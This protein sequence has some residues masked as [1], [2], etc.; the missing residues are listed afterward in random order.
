M[1]GA[2]KHATTFPGVPK[3]PRPGDAVW[4]A[5]RPL[6]PVEDERLARAEEPPDFLL[7]P[8]LTLDAVVS[9]LHLPMLAWGSIGCCE[10]SPRTRPG[11]GPANETALVLL[12][13]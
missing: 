5:K 4:V 3:L 13:G 9:T 7:G 1:L 10:R 6:A 2:S 12:T 11:L 8:T